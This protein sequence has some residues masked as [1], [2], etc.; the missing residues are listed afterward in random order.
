LFVQEIAI[1]AI[2]A[3]INKNNIRDKLKLSNQIIVLLLIIFLKMF[4]KLNSGDSN[5]LS[6]NN[7]GIT[8]IAHQINQT[9]NLFLDRIELSIYEKI[10]HQITIGISDIK[11]IRIMEI[12]F[13]IIKIF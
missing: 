1:K 11:V 10:Y 7:I 4:R 13:S 8:E 9:L 2:Q 5:I 3:S 12:I 6:K